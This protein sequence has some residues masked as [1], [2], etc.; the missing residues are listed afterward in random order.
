MII[1]DFPDDIGQENNTAILVVSCKRFEQVWD[2]F[3]ILFRKFWPDCPYK[4]YFGIDCGSHD[5]AN[6]ITIKTGK[7]IGWGNIC[8]NAVN[9]IPANRI[10]LFLE[11]FILKGP[12]NTQE[13]RRL[14]KYSHDNDI[15][16]LRLCPCPGPSAVWQDCESLGLIKTN[17][18][19]RVSL[20]TAIW[21]KSILNKIIHD[22]DDAWTVETSGIDRAKDIKE[23]FLSVWRESEDIPGGP[24][25][26][27][28]TAVV[29][30][31]WHIDGINL[32]KRENI[33]TDNITI[34]IP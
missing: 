27:V 30:G 24:I 7:D 32:L 12:A 15:G 4:I 19:Y 20:Q 31:K 5:D 17:D 3:F 26:Y 9:K 2:P 8:L 22:G 23:P 10:I 13:I 33:S 11:D 34:E 6:I 21:K 25:P 16:C 29:K 14:V 1:D 28:I 18:D